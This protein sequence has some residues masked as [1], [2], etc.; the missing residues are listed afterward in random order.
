M[1]NSRLKTALLTVTLLSGVTS[2]SQDG[3]DRL[4]VTFENQSSL[5]QMKEGK[6]KSSHPAIQKLIDEHAIVSVS[7]ALPD[8]RREDLQM[9]YEIDCFCNGD[10]LA[11]E[12]KKVAILKDP[13][14]GPKY[15]LLSLPDDY[16]VEFPQDYALDLINAEE[17]WSYT[18]G[19]TNVIL[20]IS[21]G[22]FLTEHEELTSKYV[23]VTNMVNASMNYYY[24]GTAVATTAA[25]ATDNLVGKSAIGYNCKLALN[26]IGYNQ[27]LQLHYSGARVLNASW[28]TGCSY[29]AYTQQV[30]DEIY[31]DG[32]IVVAAAGNGNATCGSA[33]ALVYPAALNHV[34]AVSSVGP[35]DNHERYIGDPNSTHQHNSSVDICAPGYDVALTISSGTY[36][37]GNGTSFASPYVAGTIGLLLSVRPCLTFENVLEILQTTAVNIDAQNSAYIGGLGAG[38]LDAGAAM[39]YISTYLCDGVDLGNSGVIDFGNNPNIL[40]PGSGM[41]PETSNGASTGNNGGIISTHG[42]NTGTIGGSGPT[43]PTSVEYTRDHLM[44]SNGNRVGESTPTVNQDE[45][46]AVLFPNPSN[47]IANLKWTVAGDVELQVY[48]STGNLVLNKKIGSEESQTTIEVGNPGVYFIQLRSAGEQIWTQKLVKL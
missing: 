25:G 37:Y 34:I 24:H 28:T 1:K 12:M 36:M 23:S 46:E 4:W 9:V 43:T 27:L 6:L 18:H 32:G 39:E 17:A 11:E 44:N 20:G 2:F 35:N 3:T 22:S 40:N 7:Q 42:N 13:V 10:A 19:D 21:D 30:I 45:F 47:G 31:E 16:A 33:S 38:R 5:P 41:N 14:E 29:N 26:T 15:E 8:S 48:S